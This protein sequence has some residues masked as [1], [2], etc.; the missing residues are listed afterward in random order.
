MFGAARCMLEGNFPVDKVC[1]SYAVL[2][3]AHK[4]ITRGLP[5]AERALLF[6]GTAKRVY[7]LP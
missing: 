5:D 1:M 2:W 6:S 3:N 4:K 7:R